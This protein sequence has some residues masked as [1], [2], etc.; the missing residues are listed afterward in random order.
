MLAVNLYMANRVLHQDAGN[1]CTAKA[2]VKPMVGVR[3]VKS[4]VARTPPR[5]KTD[6]DDMAEA[7]PVVLSVDARPPL[8]AMV[9]AGCTAGF[10]FA[11]SKAAR[12]KLEPR[13]YASATGGC[14]GKKF[15]F[16]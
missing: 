16:V 2:N 15:S 10:L 4:R 3:V 7:V 6:V 14:D 11:P 8:N 9:C 1:V 13:A 5:A 12:V